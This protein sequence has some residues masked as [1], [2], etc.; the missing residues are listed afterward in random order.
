MK[1]ESTY[2]FQAAPAVMTAA[3]LLCVFVLAIPGICG[4]PSK[5]AKTEPQS[6][7]TAVFEA[8]RQYFE[9]E[10]ARDLPAVY[11]CLAPSSAYCATHDYAAFLAEANA[12]PVRIVGYKIVRIAHIRNNE[13][14]KG[15][16]SV[17]KYAYVEVDV[18]VHYID[19]NE[20]AE[21][22]FGFMFIKERGNWYKG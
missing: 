18:V 22:N 5:T 15:F 3:I 2:G 21:V 16:P 14:V 7:Q 1:K 12:S 19:K 4:E 10:V 17:E 6:E 9:A 8:A 13:D 20:K 11:R